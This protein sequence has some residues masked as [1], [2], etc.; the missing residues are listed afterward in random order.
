MF[1]FQISFHEDELVMGFRVL[2]GHIFG[3]EGETARDILI[4][5]MLGELVLFSYAD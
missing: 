3:G 4:F 2:F 5:G 1:L